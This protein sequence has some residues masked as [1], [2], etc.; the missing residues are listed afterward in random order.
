MK[1]LR[2]IVGV[3]E[4]FKKSDLENI[5]KHHLN[6]F[7]KAKKR[8]VEQDYHSIN[9][10]RARRLIA[11]RDKTGRKT[12]GADKDVVRDNLKINQEKSQRSKKMVQTMNAKKGKK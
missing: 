12:A 2:E 11:L 8:S 9:T 4:M 7:R 1:H 6:S 3:S 5:E 10:D